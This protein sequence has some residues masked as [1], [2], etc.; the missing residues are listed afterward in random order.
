MKKILTIFLPY[1]LILFLALPQTVYSQEIT[2]E[3]ASVTSQSYS[4]A[5]S[6]SEDRGGLLL[7]L[8]AVSGIAVGTTRV[9]KKMK[10]TVRAY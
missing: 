6:F 1:L 7:I 10:K 4:I 5:D 3:A 9:S 8:I 2:N